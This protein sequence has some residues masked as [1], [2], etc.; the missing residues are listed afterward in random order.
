[1]RPVPVHNHVT[2]RLFRKA[3][4]SPGA[5]MANGIEKGAA[6]APRPSGNSYGTGRSGRAQIDCLRALAHAVGLD[7][8]RD[9][10]AIEQALHAG[11]LQ[12]RDMDE[13]VLRAAIRRDEAKT[14]GG[15][16]ELDGTSL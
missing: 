9:L 16:E 5:T 4:N 2:A 10:L 6:T 14:L 1:M 13:D 3:E 15:V 7:V 8:E 12:R 11:A